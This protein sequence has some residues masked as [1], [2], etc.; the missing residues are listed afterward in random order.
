MPDYPAVTVLPT[1]TQRKGIVTATPSATANTLGTAQFVN[2]ASGAAGLL[3]TAVRVV[4]GGTFNAETLTYNVTFTFSDNSTLFFQATFTATAVTFD[5]ALGNLLVN[6]YKDGLKCIS[7]N[8]ACQ[9]TI[10]SSA[11]TATMTVV[12]LNT[13]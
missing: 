9:S 7:V 4:S 1:Q 12:G 11:A 3:P 13:Q 6:A 8:L 2:P 5:L 10:G